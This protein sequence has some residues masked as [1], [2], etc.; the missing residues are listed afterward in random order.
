MAQF[1]TQTT[2]SSAPRGLN[3]NYAFV[4]EAGGR[5]NLSLRY[6]RGLPVRSMV[7]MAISCESIFGKVSRSQRSFD[8]SGFQDF[9]VSK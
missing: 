3:F 1:F 5:P 6:A 4:D 8:L 9:Q 7:T 2:G